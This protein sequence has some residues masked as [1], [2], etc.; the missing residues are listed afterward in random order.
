MGTSEYLSAPI[1]NIPPTLHIRIF[2]TSALFGKDKRAKPAIFKH[3]NVLSDVR[4]LW[5][6]KKKHFG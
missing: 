1:S 2:L 3:S 5:R 6:E 4:K